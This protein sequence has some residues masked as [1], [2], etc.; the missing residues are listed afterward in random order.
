MIIRIFVHNP[1]FNSLCNGWGSTK[2]K[3]TTVKMFGPEVCT[4]QFFNVKRFHSTCILVLTTSMGVLPNTLAAP[5]TPPLQNVQNDPMSLEL[6][7]PC[8]YFFSDVYTKKR[9]AWLLPCLRMV[10]NSPL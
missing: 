1:K 5:A 3:A 8:R 7:P 6:S 4:V 10:G 9:I 2:R